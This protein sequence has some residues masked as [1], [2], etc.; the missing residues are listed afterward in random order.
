[1]CLTSDTRDLVWFLYYS[2]ACSCLAMSKAAKR[3]LFFVRYPQDSGDSVA[4]KYFCFLPRFSRL[5]KC[6]VVRKA[7]R[8]RR[9]RGAFSASYPRFNESRISLRRSTSSDGSFAFSSFAS[10]S[11]LAATASWALLIPF[12]N[13]K[14]ENATMM[15]S[16]TDCTNTP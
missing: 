10:S 15:K 2:T 1:M 5:K 12:T 16:M 3:G 14:I 4:T 9:S 11:F 13:I 7:P 6:F 8:D